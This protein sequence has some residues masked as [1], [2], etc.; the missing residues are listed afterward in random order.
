LTTANTPTSNDSL[1]ND[2]DDGEDGNVSIKISRAVMLV[3]EAAKEGRV[4]SLADLSTQVK[5]S[6][7]HLQ[8]V[9]K[10]MRGVTPR[11][12]AEGIIKGDDRADAKNGLVG[13]DGSPRWHA[14]S[15]M[16]SNVYTHA[17]S[18]L[19]TW[20]SP[21]CSPQD[22]LPDVDWSC[23][24]GIFWEERYPMMG[25]SSTND[26][27]DINFQVPDNDVLAELFPELFNH[28]M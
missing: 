9:F 12:M 6:K 20:N 15:S 16:D 22:F 23:E 25:P 17:G 21:D 26:V 13:T 19:M 1:N 28:Q 18:D 10:K 2:D 3:R 24:D 27:V 14:I 7:F 4:I 11:E 5:L 8:R